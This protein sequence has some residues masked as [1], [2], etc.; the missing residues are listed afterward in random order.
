[1]RTRFASLLIVVF[2]LVFPSHCVAESGKKGAFASAAIVVGQKADDLERLAAREVQRYLCRISGVLV[3]L[4]DEGVWKAEPKRPLILVGTVESNPLVA[5]VAGTLGIP[6]AEAL[7][8]QGFV[9][10]SAQVEGRAVVVIAAASPVGVLYGAYTFLEQRGVGFYLGGDTFP[11]RDLPLEIPALDIQRKPVFAV[12]GSL[13]WYNFLNSPTT[14]DLD[15]FKYFFDQMSKMKNNFVGFHT[16]DS[17]PF[18][19]YKE[20]GKLVYAAPLVT[21]L[22]YGWGGVRGLRTDQFGFGT[23]DYFDQDLFGSRATTQSKDAEDAIRRAQ[24]LLA[25]GLEYG[26]RRGVRVCVGFEVTGDPTE[27]KAQAD[28]EKR[29]RELV[30]AYPMLDYVWLWQSE[31]RGGGAELPT[32]DAPLDV[33]VQKQRKH[34]EYL[35]DPRRIA[36]A[37]RVSEYAR[38][39]HAI[40]KRIAPRMRVIV[41]GW[42]GD[43]WMRFS[44]FYEGFDKTLP[45][46]VIFAALDN[47]NPAAEPN[48]SAVYGK[49]SPKRERWPIPWYESDGGGPRRDQFCPQ[50]NAK[51][52]TFLCRDAL[53]K[54]CQGLLAIHWRSR[55]VEE[56]AAYSAQ[57]AWEPKLT[58]EEFYRRFAEK[59]FGKEHAGELG[60]IL[61]QLE[62]LGPRWTGGGGQSECGL[63]TWFEGN[64]LPK[65]E[66]LKILAQIRQRLAQVRSQME[67]SGRLEGLERISHLITTIDWV[68]QYDA[69][70]VKLYPGGQ[71]PK[72]IAEAESLNR[73][74]DAQGAAKKA[75]EAWDALQSSGLRE[76][77]CAFPVKMTTRGEFGA[78]ATINVKAYGSCL[79]LEEQ[80]RS[81]VSTPA[82][83]G[84]PAAQALPEAPAPVQRALHV[85]VKTPP[86]LV[87]EKRPVTV[88]AA[89]IG[90][91]AI[92]QVRL[93]YRKLGEKEFRFVPMELFFRKTY[94][95]IIPADAVTADGIEFF[96][97]AKD[98]A[99]GVACA[100][101]GS[102][103][104][105]YS[106]GV[107]PWPKPS[108][109][110]TRCRSLPRVGQEDYI[111]VTVMDR[112][113]NAKVNL[114]YRVAGAGAK[115]D[116]KKLAMTN[117]LYDWFGATVPGTEV[118]PAGI[119]YFVEVEGEHGE[120]WTAP[121]AGAASPQKDVP[122]MVPPDAVAG[123]KAEV[124][125]PYEVKL[126]WANATDNVGILGYEVY[127]GGSRSFPL[128]SDA[129][130][131]GTYKTEHYDIHVR[132]GETYWYAVRAKDEAGNLGAAGEYASVT[133]PKYPPPAAP[134]NV[135]TAAGRGKIKVSW[136]AMD[137][138]IVGYNVYRTPAGAPPE[139]GKPVLLNTRGLVRQT[140]FIDGGLK[141]VVS[142][143]YAVRAVDR[144][145][146]EGDASAPVTASPLARM[147]APAF[148]AHF[149]NSPDA[150]SGL[151]GKLVG[152]AAY[153]PGVVGKALD[154]GDGGWVAFDHHEVFDLVGELTLEA[155]VKFNSLEGMPVFLSHGQWRERGFFVQAI[156]H[157]IRYSL[158]SLNDCDA[159]RLEPGKWYYVVCTY[160]L[161]DMRVYL[162][163]REVGRRD[164]PEVD[165][166]P[167]VGPF[168]VGRY[169]LEGKPYEVSGLIDE[170]KIYQRARTAEEILKEYEAVSRSLPQ[171]K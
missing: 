160:D 111:P 3:P 76:A 29:L 34:F 113:P 19:P 96:V 84:K 93:G 128:A 12:R 102:P 103:C 134:R 131:T 16:Y 136:D 119:E 165:L 13:P 88:R 51:E 71:V 95:G 74:G 59:C 81:V 36:E 57:F 26:K 149:E 56:P 18:A 115:G 112:P 148:V 161:K 150:E 53:A 94:Q 90:P 55:D 156:G 22:N 80:I 132:P 129:L 117:V 146:Q 72:L 130:V 105:T 153:A 33:L 4:A 52:F 46:D 54:G 120:K 92:A 32:L 137:L 1:M 124:A 35:K 75:R 168:Y 65:E 100:P 23:G 25:Q 43:K 8:D 48:V 10:K 106:A 78:L 163:G 47:I 139:S 45:P 87:P 60:A 154:L 143:R 9:V 15:D 169:T 99:G 135:K 2:A 151:K 68:V 14:W 109:F 138:P 70:A 40:L 63:F 86:S 37:V 82:A 85:V 171:G 62:S 83:P 73:K 159:G 104:A 125:G 162:N 110:L 167:W 91:A 42:G 147:E 158:G 118:T 50:T 157:G 27:G 122:D 6:T 79:G 28:L 164:T 67:S 127:R 108:V 20:N 155:W 142:Y 101:K 126:S 7:G 116:Y 152:K 24:A 166:T 58:Y 11:G 39:G 141:D 69:A 144:G 98:S 121:P 44:D 31:G 107:T 41:S 140:A 77:M 30:R 97:E 123:L 66:N 89:V 145:G 17:E 49:L 64:E 21:S 61:R 5:S 133:I 114:F 170:V 38:L